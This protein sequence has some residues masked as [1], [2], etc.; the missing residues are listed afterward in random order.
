MT[1]RIADGTS[2]T[3]RI[4]NARH[5]LISRHLADRGCTRADTVAGR[6]SAGT[7]AADT[8]YDTTGTGTNA[9]RS[10]PTGCSA[11]NVGAN[12]KRAAS[13]G[14]TGL[15][16]TRSNATA[17]TV[18]TTATGCSASDANTASCSSRRS[19]GATPFTPAL[20]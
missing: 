16:S 12:R 1:L 19:T 18:G 8:R 10:G 20:S 6:C 13:P 11:A 3:L 5:A 9:T 2:G 14:A 4:L 15:R 17:A 7:N